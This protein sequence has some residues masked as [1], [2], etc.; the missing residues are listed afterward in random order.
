ML[1]KNC[2]KTWKNFKECYLHIEFCHFYITKYEGKF[3]FFVAFVFGFRQIKV[4]IDHCYCHWQYK[5]CQEGER[6]PNCFSNR[7]KDRKDYR[8]AEK[9]RYQTLFYVIACFP[10]RFTFFVTFFF[11]CWL[12][13][14]DRRRFAGLW[15]K[16][17]FCVLFF[18]KAKICFTP[19]YFT[20]V[21]L[22]SHHFRPETVF[23]MLVEKQ[24]RQF[25]FC[26]LKVIQTYDSIWDKVAQLCAAPRAAGPTVS[27]AMKKHIGPIP[28]PKKNWETA[29]TPIKQKP[30]HEI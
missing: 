13:L 17:F 5:K 20:I 24:G 6:L 16:N 14:L 28:M 30:I 2:R 4:Q 29:M 11:A 27:A 21:L 12:T 25:F 9:Q 23:A 1:K 10:G 15:R 8:A 26:C 18:S 7:Q 3:Y 22:S 19:K